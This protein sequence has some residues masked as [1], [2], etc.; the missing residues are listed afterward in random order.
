MWAQAKSAP[1]ADLSVALHTVGD[2]PM[3]RENEI[4]KEC[5]PFG[6]Q[7]SIALN[8]ALTGPAIHCPSIAP[9]CPGRFEIHFLG[10]VPR[11]DPVRM[12]PCGSLPAFAGR[13]SRS[14]GSRR[15]SGE[16]GTGAR[17]AQWLKRAVAR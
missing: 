12:G 4:A 17:R 1:H 3:T 10:S 8:H 11:H 5:R 6:P 13:L 9:R 14:G 7:A 15:P 16:K 2:H